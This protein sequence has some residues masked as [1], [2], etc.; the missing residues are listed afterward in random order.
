MGFFILHFKE[1]YFI[2]VRFVAVEIADGTWPVALGSGR[3]LYLFIAVACGETK[4]PYHTIVAL[5]SLWQ[6]CRLRVEVCCSR[7]R[8]LGEYSIIP[9][10][11]IINN[12][13]N[14]NGSVAGF[15]QRITL[16]QKYHE[17]S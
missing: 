2:P 17:S 5:G 14:N 8:L 1:S 13:N 16:S 3:S 10:Y 6:R 15:F 11:L 4:T 12:N 9:N 7:L